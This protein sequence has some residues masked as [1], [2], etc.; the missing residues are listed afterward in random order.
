MR[1]LKILIV[2][3]APVGSRKGNRVTAR[4][5]ATILRELGHRV[6]VRENYT[7][8]RCDILIALHAGRTLVHGLGLLGHRHPH[9]AVSIGRAKSDPA[10]QPTLD[11]RALGRGT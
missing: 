9:E 11:P 1:N 5:W 8:E 4:R 6:R 2:T 3:P 7:A 10:L